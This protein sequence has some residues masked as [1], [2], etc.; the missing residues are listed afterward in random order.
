MR[1]EAEDMRIAL[2]KGV[3]NRLQREVKTAQRL[4]NLRLYKIAKSILMIAEGHPIYEIAK[5]FNVTSRTI[6]NW[7]AR[8]LAKR[9]SWLLGYHYRGRGRKCKLTKG[10]RDQLYQIV[11]KGPEQY[12]F[13]CGIWTAAMI[14]EVVFHEFNVAYNPRYLCSLLKKIGLSYQKAGFE[15]D[16][17]DEEKRKE[18]VEITFPKILKQAK[19]QKAVIVFGDEVSFAQWGSLSRTWAPRGKQPKIKTT[20]KRKGLKIFGAIGLFEGDFHYME[21]PEKFNAQ[22]YVQFLEQLVARYSQPIILVEDGAKYHSG[23]I[24]NEFKDTMKAKGRL[25]TYRLPSYS[26]DYNPIEKLWKKTKADATHCKYF[27]TFEHLRTAVIKAFE[28]YMNDARK[29]LSVMK[30][31]RA[32]AGIA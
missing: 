9:F 16:H 23:S 2:T 3:K 4:S 26:P 20:G 15:S 28:K 14:A 8:F 11:E 6:S 24:A 25:Y 17:L 30:K 1:K 7:L 31:L 18:W 12:G 27:P 29:V 13:D 32:N 22:T 5:F 19:D 21:T 10:Q